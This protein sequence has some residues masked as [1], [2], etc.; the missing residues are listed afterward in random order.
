MVI[1]IS[2][3]MDCSL[4]L[5]LTFNQIASPAAQRSGSAGHEFHAASG[6]LLH[7][8]KKK[9]V[10]R[11]AKKAG[12]HHSAFDL[13]VVENLREGFSTLVG[14]PI[15]RSLFISGAPIYL[16]FGLWNVLLLPFAINALGATE[17][18]YGLQEGL[19]S[20]AS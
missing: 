19:T 2:L 15:L 13:L 3:P 20:V 14:T 1:L 12:R 16:S 7:P 18:E 9:H 10:G 8:Q 4:F 11:N 17:F 6:T 5:G